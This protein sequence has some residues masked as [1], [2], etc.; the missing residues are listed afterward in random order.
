MDMCFLGGGGEG[1]YQYEQVFITKRQFRTLL[2]AWKRLKRKM[3]ILFRCQ[4]FP[5]M[6][7]IIIKL[8]FYS[9][10]VL[11]NRVYRTGIHT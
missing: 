11:C 9:L 4:L 2:S 5:F 8:K 3:G 6:R 7:K 10:Y 1:V